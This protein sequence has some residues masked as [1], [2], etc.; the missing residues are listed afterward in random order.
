[1]NI[2]EFIT[3]S[4]SIHNNKYNYELSSNPKSHD[5][6][7]II[8]PKHG[9]FIQRAIR[10]LNGSGCKKC[11]HEN[12]II[13]SSN[14]FIEKAKAIHG[15][16]YDYS[17]VKYI[18]C[19][20]GIEIICSE[21]GPF[22]QIPSSHLA[23]KGCSECANNKKHTKDQFI[24]KAKAIHGD[25]YDYS[26]VKYNNSKHKIKIICPKHG[27]FEQS[28][29]A[30][31]RYG[32]KKCS[33]MKTSESRVMKIDEFIKRAKK[34]HNNIYDYSKT[35][36]HRYHDNIEIICSKHG[37]FKQT[38]ANHLQGH[39]CPSCTPI[40]SKPCQ[41]ISKFLDLY[42]IEHKCNDRK[43]L[44][45]YELDIWI[46]DHSFA[47]EYHGLY[48]HSYD[49]LENVDEKNK[50]LHKAD[51]AEKMGIN[52]I[53]IFEDEWKYKKDLIKSMI[54]S[55][56]NSNNKIY[57]RKCKIKDV[58]NI[59]YKQFC[60][61]NHIQG[62]RSAAY[63]YG[64]YFNDELVFIMSFNKKKNYY[65]I[66]RM[67]SKQGTTIIGGASKLFKYF[68]NK[69]NPDEVI[70]YCNRR[71]GTGNVYKMM[72]MNL[73]SKTKPNYFYC[74]HLKRQ[75]RIKFQKHKLINILENFDSNLTEAEN[76]FNNGY[77]RIWDAGNYKFKWGK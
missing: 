14:Q 19:D 50:H 28:P 72:G 63:R 25:K 46:P 48:W 70:S 58:L 2:K 1:M 40:F 55:R 57:A 71:Y 39:G 61:G 66:E 75:G 68:I 69:Y 60:E 11:Y 43:Q 16:K 27:V 74:R 33:N 77:R 35:L 49:K 30:H 47:I 7:K 53:Q 24:K 8:C 26:K 18:R 5:N 32:C 31:F 45:P 38:P 52:L 36:Y 29:N 42:G 6:I 65:E 4:N 56:I 12:R 21:H 20:A 22:W 59:Q 37:T 34:I 13:K 3:K 9:L 73:I 54:L 67:C 76:M 15:D 41:D 51:M 17:K 23:G 62:Y 64:L 44:Y 10:H